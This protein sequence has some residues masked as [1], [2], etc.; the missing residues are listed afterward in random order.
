MNIVIFF[1][2][3]IAGLI[4]AFRLQRFFERVAEEHNEERLL[5]PTRRV[6]SKGYIV[7]AGIFTLALAYGLIFADSINWQANE[8]V[9]YGG[10]FQDMASASDSAK[11]VTALVGLVVISVCILWYWFS[12][13]KPRR[14]RF[15]T[16]VGVIFFILGCLCIFTVA[17]DYSTHDVMLRLVHDGKIFTVA[18]N[19]FTLT[20]KTFAGSGVSWGTLV[21]G[22]F[23]WG[24]AYLL[25]FR[26]KPYENGSLFC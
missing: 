15:P 22:L 3:I 13:V 5:C 24:C 25:Q 23:F 18:G 12:K 16:V 17:I 14:K 6:G 4:L 7:L 21:A 20:E 26:P 10:V 8:P 1:I 2:A 19:T 9:P 11:A